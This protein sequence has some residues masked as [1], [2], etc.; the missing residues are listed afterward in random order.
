MRVR[1]KRWMR[2]ARVSREPRGR[3]RE[4]SPCQTRSADILKLGG[5]EVAAISTNHIVD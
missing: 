3:S 5:C 4:T 1:V 2:E